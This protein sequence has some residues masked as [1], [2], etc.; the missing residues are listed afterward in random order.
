MSRKTKPQNNISK[1]RKTTKMQ[2]MFRG[3]REPLVN[4]P[5][6]KQV[7]SLTTTSN[8][9]TSLSLVLTP[10]GLMSVKLSSTVFTAVKSDDPHLMWLNT[11]AQNFGYYRV[12]RAK[13]VFIGNSG[14]TTSGTLNL[15]GSADPADSTSNIQ[16]AFLAGPG[17]K[18]FD[19]ASTAS[20]EASL[21]IPVD[22]SWKKVSQILMRPA[23][24]DSTIITPFNSL[25]DLSFA[26][27]QA[28]VVGVP[29]NTNLGNLFLDY[30]VEFKDP[31]S[32]SMNL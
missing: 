6:D 29:L 16:T 9:Y 4:N 17:A 21:T 23:M 20:K 31:L 10:I 1:S 15:F 22:S 8:N 25:G 30:D 24:S 26:T 27:I 28:Q 11:N 19:L 12:T 14:S 7:I 32:V 3:I 18:S 2:H 13:L 5:T